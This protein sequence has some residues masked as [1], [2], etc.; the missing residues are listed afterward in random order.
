VDQDELPTPEVNVTRIELQDLYRHRFSE[1]DRHAKAK[2]WQVIVS[3]FLQ[4]WIAPDHVVI[5]L[6][7]GD[8]EFL[9][10][11]RCARRVGVDGN[12]D[13]AQNLDTDIEFH[14]ENIS[15]LSFL[16]NDSVDT[17]F[18]SNVLEHLASKDEVAQVVLEARRV[19]KPGGQFLALG[20]NLRL[21]PG[22]YWDF[23]DHHVPLTDRSLV[24]LLTTTG[25]RIATCY[26]RF[27]PYTTRSALPQAP[28]LVW[29]YLKI[30]P[31]WRLFGKQFFIRAIK[32]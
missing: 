22:A 6:G 23:W 32:L 15:D 20:P 30:P 21:L 31:L 18:T 25:F 8:G 1:P 13:A 17:S 29:L 2:V 28:Q 19:L 16:P 3:S 10:Y 12:P 14:H 26:P 5:D 11:V 9:T 24:E 4:Q 7:C 27:L